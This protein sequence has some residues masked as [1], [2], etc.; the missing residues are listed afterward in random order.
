MKRHGQNRITMT[1]I[2]LIDADIITYGVAFSVETPVYICK[3]GVYRRKGFAEYMSEKNGYPVTKRVNV[4]SEQEL[5]RNLNKKLAGIFDDCGSRNYEMY[6]TASKVENNFRSKISTIMTYKGNRL[7]MIKPVHYNR[8]RE[9]L[10]KEY[11]A[12]LVEGQEA[13]DTLSMRQTELHEKH[14]DYEHSIIASIDKDLL[15]V[16]GYNYNFNSRKI[17]L[18]SEEMALK[19]FYK[20]L[21]IGDVTDNI[22]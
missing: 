22:P 10:V 4:G 5:R 2:I 13:D 9:I 16:P 7:R 17:T 14:G 6:L 1:Q 8:M 20:Q 15:T 19:N 12:I 3:G 21:L 18:I 11:G